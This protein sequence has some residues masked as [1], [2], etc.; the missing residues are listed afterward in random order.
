[1]VTNVM[2][3]Q[4][5]TTRAGIDQLTTQCGK[6]MQAATRPITSHSDFILWSVGSFVWIQKQKSLTSVKW[7][8]NVLFDFDLLRYIITS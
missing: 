3:K 7:I 5:C 2:K 4:N 6:H 1:M 8:Q